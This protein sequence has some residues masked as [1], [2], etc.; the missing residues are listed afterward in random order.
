M[1]ETR[2]HRLRRLRLR[3]MRRGIK[4]MDLALTAYA[5]ARLERMS[6]AELD[7]YEAL[8]QEADQDLLQW[9]LGRA[10]PPG[11]FAPML[12]EIA[13]VLQDRAGHGA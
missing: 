4:E 13:R 3:S 8:L 2:E 6:A 5:E 1:T 12:A 7:L 9:L 10:A 11:R